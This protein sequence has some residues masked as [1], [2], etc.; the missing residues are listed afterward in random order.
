M[1]P[2][3]ATAASSGLRVT[4]KGDRPFHA[5]EGADA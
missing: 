2:A 5:T 3:P 1:T 4:V